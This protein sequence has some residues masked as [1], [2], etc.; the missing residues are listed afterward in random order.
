MSASSTEISRLESLITEISNK[1]N[2]FDNLND[3]ESI[4][5]GGLSLRSK[6][7]VVA[8]LSIN[9]PHERGGLVVDFHTLMEHVHHSINGTDAIAK[10]NGC[11]LY[12]SPSPRDLK[13]SRMPSSA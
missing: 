13:L 4:K 5:F 12:T 7:E 3:S 11:L 1:V 2:K 10:L 6:K 8:W 9:A